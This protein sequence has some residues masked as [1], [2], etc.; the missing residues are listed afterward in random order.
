M[1]FLGTCYCINSK[2]IVTLQKLKNNTTVKKELIKI[3]CSAEEIAREKAKYPEVIKDISRIY[4]TT[5][6][7]KYTFNGYQSL[8]I[9]NTERVYTG[10]VDKPEVLITFL[11]ENDLTTKY[12]GYTSHIRDITKTKS[13]SYGKKKK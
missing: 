12:I 5:P 3:K 8:Y 2:K 4:L 10:N 9:I 6:L 7:G 1:A 13:G 11:F